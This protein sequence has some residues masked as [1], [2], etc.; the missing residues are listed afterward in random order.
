MKKN[1]IVLILVSCLFISWQQKP[2]KAPNIVLIVADDL[3]YSGLGCFGSEI[4][5]PN[6]DALAK[7][8]QIF[9]NFYSLKNRAIFF[10]KY[11]V[12]LFFFVDFIS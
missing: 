7:H 9:T 11:L 12:S 1:K 8:G 10:N 5:T 2:A 4:A 3:G 6:I